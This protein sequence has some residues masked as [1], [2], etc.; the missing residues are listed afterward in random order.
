[1]ILIDE[2]TKRVVWKL[3]TATELLTG[4]DNVTRVA[5]VK[6]VNTER[7]RFLHLSVKHLIPVELNTNIET[8]DDSSV[9][10]TND[11]HQDLSS[12]S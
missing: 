5:I 4:R 10:V 8:S 6:T 12:S 9:P 7:T 1:M 11:E 3:T 2:F